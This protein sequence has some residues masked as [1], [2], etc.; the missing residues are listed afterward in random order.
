MATAVELVLYDPRWPADFQRIRG[1]LERLLAPYVI[2]IE[3]IGS[4]SI[5]GLAAK[6]LVDI[7]LI[8]R[9]SDDIPPA[10]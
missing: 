6:P 9:S 8:L 4:T 1:R 7:D 3:H 2:A 10:T 5:P